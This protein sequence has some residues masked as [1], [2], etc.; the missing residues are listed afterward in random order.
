MIN[1]NK[2]ILGYIPEGTQCYPLIA[3]ENTKGLFVVYTRNDAVPRYTKFGAE[4]AVAKFTISIVSE[5]YTEGVEVTNKIIS[6]ILK[7]RNAQIENASETYNDAFIQ[8]LTINIIYNI[9]EY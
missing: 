6:S 9:W 7:D 3:P 4:E 8:E 5:N 2:K 1:I